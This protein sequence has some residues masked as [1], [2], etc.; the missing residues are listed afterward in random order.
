[1]WKDGDEWR[2]AEENRTSNHHIRPQHTD[3]RDA[4]PR[5][6]DSI[7]STESREDHCKTTTHCAE[8]GL[9]S[10]LTLVQDTNWQMREA[11]SIGG[12]VL[13]RERLGTGIVLRLNMEDWKYLPSSLVIPISFHLEL[14]SLKPKSFLPDDAMLEAPR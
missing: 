10:I 9:P 6:C 5:F 7:R 13:R 2:E 4:Y 1:M 12:A 11:Y 3:G 8:E 14:G